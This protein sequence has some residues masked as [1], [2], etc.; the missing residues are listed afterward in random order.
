MRNL[1]VTNPQT[2]F[3]LGQ[4]Q[5]STVLLNA[6]FFHGA[7]FLSSGHVRGIYVA[8]LSCSIPAFLPEFL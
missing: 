1:G 2:Q 5:N 4:L 3:P 8:F 7:T 6:R